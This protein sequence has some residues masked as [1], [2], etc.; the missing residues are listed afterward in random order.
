MVLSAPGDHETPRSRSGIAAVILGIVF[1]LL[2]APWISG[3]AKSAFDTDTIDIR[4]ERGT[5]M[6]VAV[7]PDGRHLVFDLLGSIYQVPLSGGKAEVLIGGHVTGVEGFFAAAVSHSPAVSATGRI[8]FISDLSGSENLWVLDAPGSTPRQLTRHDGINFNSPVWSEEGRSIFVR[9]STTGREGELWQYDVATGKGERLPLNDQMVDLQGPAFHEG[10]LYFAAPLIEQ[11]RRPLR[12]ETWQI[13]RAEP[14]S[15]TVEAVTDVPGGAVRP[16]ISPNGRWL[17]YGTWMDGKSSLALRDRVSGGEQVL[18][19]G[20]PRNLQDMYVAQLDLLP[21]YAF[22]PDSSAIFIGRDGRLTRVAIPSGD[23][24]SIEFQVETTV[25]VPHVKPDPVAVPE[26]GF[27]PRMLR[28]PRAAADGSVIFEAT[29]RLWSIDPDDPIRNP[30]PLTPPELFATQPDIMPDGRIAFL[31]TDTEGGRAVMLREPA[32]SVTRV[33]DNS[34]AYAAPRFTADGMHLLAV[35]AGRGAALGVISPTRRSA[36]VELVRLDL[37]TGDEEVLLEGA[38]TEAGAWQ[39]ADADGLW[40]STEEGLTR[41]SNDAA[42]ASAT[43]ERGGADLIVPSPDGSRV[44]VAMNDHVFVLPI[45]EAATTIRDL[46]ANPPAYA[47]FPG[48]HGYFPSWIDDDTLLWSIPRGIAIA[49]RDRLGEARRLVA[50][51]QVR[52]PVNA[53]PVVLRGARLL[54]MSKPSVIEAGEV[55]VA[56]GRIACVAPLGN[57]DIPGD[58]IVRDL[59][60]KT[61]MP[62]LI[63]VHQH[64]LALMGEESTKGIPRQ[65]PPTSILLAYGVTST[66]DPALLSNIRDFSLIESINAGR[67]PGPRYFAT[68]ERVMPERVRV[69]GPDDARAIVSDLTSVGATSIKEYLLR[70]RR[71]RQ[72][73]RA[74]AAEAD[75]R[76]TFEGG[77]DYKLSL[78]A[79]LDGYD[80]LEHSAGNHVLQ[81]DFL[82]LLAATGIDYTPTILTQIGAEVFYRR[83]GIRKEERLRRFVSAQVLEYL[84]RRP[85]RGQGVAP[86]ETAYRALTTNA[87][88]AQ[89]AGVTVACGA[90]DAPAPT[91]LGTH[92]EIW[93]LVEGGMSEEAALAAATITGARVIGIE[94]QVGS[95]ERGKIADLLILQD[96]PLDDIHNTLSLETVVRN[97]N[98]LD[99]K[100]L[101]PV[102]VAEGPSS[103]ND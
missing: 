64:A 3:Y 27:T 21:G 44:A 78:G 92:W 55:V 26:A 62:G 61:I 70:D 1:A 66:R 4:T 19:S 12:R 73:L 96:N 90:H 94:S 6:G 101:E 85:R 14:A 80:G 37:S 40:L 54:T 9:R 86:E 67:V 51:F 29:G 102:A 58:A 47:G 50:E 17:A 82:Q 18:L 79:V 20:I 88:R 11:G 45:A 99:S 8:A 84:V 13:M 72:W 43:V 60:G 81:D 39:T 91:G 30:R 71:Q 87:A 56:N 97:G 34:A 76:I 95:L 35:K 22:A 93:S 75:V 7:T 46:T 41:T 53:H 32:G 59:S 48:E 42:V 15:E 89:K 16:L 38:L 100:T 63:D 31:A 5:W 74:A 28:W 24:S 65:Y 103:S 57:C 10:E 33:T 77:Y 98:L 25:R 69:D 52:P 49:P 83:H 23:I 36:A 68:G 2:G